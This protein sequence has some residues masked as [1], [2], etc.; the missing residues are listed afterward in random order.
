MPLYGKA[1]RLFS[2]LHENLEQASDHRTANKVIPLVDAM[3][4]GFPMLSI[5][6]PLLLVFKRRRFEGPES[7]H[8]GSGIGTISSDAHMRSILDILLPAHIR[9]PF[10]G[11]LPQ[12]Q[13]GKMLP[14]MTAGRGHQVLAT[15][16]IG[17]HSSENISPEFLVNILSPLKNN[18]HE[19]SSS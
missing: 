4:S 3:M 11:L 14:K 1:D 18:V 17:R 10:G 6:Y 16:G 19:K 13:W 12:L 15:D 8:H 9:R 5:K 7:L 2:L